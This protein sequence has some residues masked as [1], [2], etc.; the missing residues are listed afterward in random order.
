L[1]APKALLTVLSTKE[2][3]PF[4]NLEAFKN[5][6]LSF[7]SGNPFQALKAYTTLPILL[8]INLFMKLV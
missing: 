7:R 3:S 2:A 6:A 5:A 8:F 1:N 4:S